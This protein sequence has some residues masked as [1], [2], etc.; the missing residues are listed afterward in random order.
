MTAPRHTLLPLLLSATAALSLAGGRALALSP[1]ELVNQAQEACLAG[2]AQAG[3]PREAAQLRSGRALDGDRA[4][5]VFELR[6]NGGTA[7]LTCPYSASKGLLAPVA[8]AHSAASGGSAAHAATGQ[9]PSA[10]TAAAN[11]H[12]DTPGAG[13]P[14][15]GAPAAGSPSAPE[16]ESPYIAAQEGN[17]NEVEANP[18]LRSLEGTVTP[19]SEKESPYIAAQEQSTD[20][21]EPMGRLWGLLVPIALAAGSYA[22][23]RGRDGEANR[24]G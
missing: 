21:P 8:A 22:L 1:R 4:E 17:P 16:R 15:S 13:A 5:V 2:A 10:P 12:G 6:R 19:G 23:L 9:A 11:P 7:R 24:E 14:A 18:V 3:W 20:A